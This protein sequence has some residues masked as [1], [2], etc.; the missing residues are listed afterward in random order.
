MGLKVRLKHYARVSVFTA[1]SGKKYIIGV[2]W[3]NIVFEIVL[4]FYVISE[5]WFHLDL[6][7]YL[8]FFIFTLASPDHKGGP[9]EAIS[10]I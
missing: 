10:L 3:R 2:C 8:G 5:K 7:N 9:I 1:T 6:S 4:H